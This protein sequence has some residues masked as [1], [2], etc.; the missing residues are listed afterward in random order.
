MA[1]IL[2]RWQ[3]PVG[4]LAPDVIISCNDT[5]ILQAGNRWPVA[6][7]SATGI[8]ACHAGTFSTI[9]L[10]AKRLTKQA[11]VLLATGR[12]PLPPGR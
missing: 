4:C 8:G 2:L 3:Y 11:T 7:F 9:K 1:A 12:G 10:L 5:S 6:T